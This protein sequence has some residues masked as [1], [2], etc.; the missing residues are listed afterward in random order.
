MKWNKVE[1]E[2]WEKDYGYMYCKR[3]E[4]EKWEILVGVVMYGYR[5]YVRQVHDRAGFTAEYCGGKKAKDVR[6]LYQTI[7]MQLSKDGKSMR[8]LLGEIP[9]MEVRPYTKDGKWIFGMLQLITGQ[10]VVDNEIT[11]VGL[12]EGRNR[13]LM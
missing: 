11:D 12:S 10:P 5:V 4:D 9:R 6:S 3:S 8:E 2:D 7:E 13:I 1:L